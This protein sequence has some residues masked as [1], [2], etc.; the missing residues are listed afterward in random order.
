VLADAA[1]RLQPAAEPEE[2][3]WDRWCVRAR[4][5]G[6]EP[7]LARLGRAVIWASRSPSVDDERRAECGWLDDGED[8]LELALD[9]PEAAAEG[10]RAVLEGSD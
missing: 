9:D 7:E 6:V 8:M 4:E 5:E 10:W 1:R 3:L 2:P